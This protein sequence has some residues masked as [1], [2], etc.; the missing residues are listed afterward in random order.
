MAKCIGSKKA[1]ITIEGPLKIVSNNPGV[2][3]E[4]TPPGGMRITLAGTG[5]R[6]DW[7]GEPLEV[8]WVD[9][10]GTPNDSYS[11]K[12]L[13][14]TLEIG[15]GAA[16]PSP[17]GQRCVQ[18]RII[19]NGQEVHKF[20]PLGW[21]AVSLKE[22]KKIPAEMKVIDNTGVIFTK[23]FAETPKFTISCDDD[24]PEGQIKGHSNRP[25]GYCCLPCGDVRDEI[26]TIKA[27]L[28]T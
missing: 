9:G 21:Y 1:T 26:A 4:L 2:D 20:A 14:C 12:I 22:V 8:S 17:T 27:M 23:E 28:R 18:A 24:C 19:K 10:S 25:P 5:V 11:L 16:S 13:T 15:C 3:V 7:V 6:S